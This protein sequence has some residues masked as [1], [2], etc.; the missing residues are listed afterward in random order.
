V[1]AYT[2][3]AGEQG[4]SVCWLHRT[5]TGNPSTRISVAAARSLLGALGVDTSLRTAPA[6]RSRHITGDAIDMQLRWTASS[7]KVQ[8]AA[9]HPVKIT[10]KP[11]DGTN[12]DLIAVGATYGVHHFA[13][14]AVDR[15]HWSSDGH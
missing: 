6:L 5:S 14:V 15:N 7:I 4:P 12:P 8:D 2:P 9:G 3:L 13:P 11:H 10:S 1:P